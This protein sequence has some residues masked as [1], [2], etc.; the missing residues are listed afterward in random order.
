MRKIAFLSLV[1]SASL[2]AVNLTHY[3]GY[4]N[5]SDS[6]KDKGYYG[7]VYGSYFKSPYKLELDVAHLNI[8]YKDSTPKY[9]QTDLTL[10][11]NYYIGYNTALKVGIH[12]I[13]IDQKGNSNKYDN[14]LFAGILYYKTYH[15]NLGLDV[16]RSNYD[17]FDVVQI[18]PK[19]G[20]NFGNYKSSLGS[21]YAEGI[22]NFIHISQPGYTNKRDYV[23]LD[24][25]LQ[26]FNGPLTTELFA[27]IG[28]NAY[29]VAKGGFV[30]YNLQE[31]YKYSF[32]A[33]VG[34][35][36]KNGSFLK[37]SYTRSKFSENSKEAKSNNFMLSFSKSF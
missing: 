8:R 21:F 1:A 4:I 19:Y 36:F 33:S 12:N 16:Y 2:Y 18:S 22:L 23:N 3:L 26:N 32:G 20:F 6:I 24:L 11:G 13:F 7:G 14:I 37:A 25:K 27:S 15:Y 34:Y 5:Y 28:K 31:E 9:K 17:G 30:V 10:I 29:K 35:S